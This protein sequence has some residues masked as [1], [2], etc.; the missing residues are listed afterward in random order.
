MFL[1]PSLNLSPAASRTPQTRSQKAEKFGFFQFLLDFFAFR[2]ALQK[3]RRKNIEKSAKIKDFG[4]PKPSQNP[5]KIELKSMSQKTCDSYRFLLEKRFVTKVPTSISYWFLQ[6]FLLV[7]H[8]FLNRFWHAFLVPKTSQKPLQNEARTLE[9]SMP[10]TCRF[11]TSI[12]LGVGLDFGGSWA[13]KLEPKSLFWPQ[14]FIMH[15]PPER[16]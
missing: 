10:K 1:Y 8:F 5:F 13:P 14:K 3:R 11:L 16:S 7:G 9:K 12:F 6:Y 2:N 15:P 4:L